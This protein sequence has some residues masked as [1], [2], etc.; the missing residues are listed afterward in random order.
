MAD[1]HEVFPVS[2]LIYP[3]RSSSS[4]LQ[5]NVMVFLDQENI[6]QMLSPRA[7]SHPFP[8]HKGSI[9]MFLLGV[10]NVSSSKLCFT[11]SSNR[12]VT[13][14]NFR[15]CHTQQGFVPYKAA[16]L[17][18]VFLQSLL[19]SSQQESSYYTTQAGVLVLQKTPP[20]YFIDKVMLIQ[21]Y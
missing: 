17:T 3:R 19:S 16:V 1:S 18:V 2:K 20:T 10:N 15:I 14:S 21:C 13:F 6:L 9:S 12:K 11:S 8:S 7:L 4:Q 5:W